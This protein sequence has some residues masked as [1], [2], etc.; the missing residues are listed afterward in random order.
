MSRVPSAPIALVTVAA[1]ALLF[2]GSC[3]GRGKYLEALL[4]QEA[5]RS[6]AAAAET[7]LADAARRYAQLQSELAGLRASYA[8]ERNEAYEQQSGGMEE[9]QRLLRERTLQGLVIDSLRREREALASQRANA[10]AIIARA[11]EQLDV[12]RQRIA[13]RTGSFLPGQFRLTTEGEALVLTIDEAAIFDDKRKERISDFGDASLANLA[14]AL[15]GRP[16]IR[17]DVVCGPREGDGSAKDLEGAAVRA[18]MVANNLVIGH[19]LLPGVVRAVG[20]AELGGEGVLPAVEYGTGEGRRV[21]RVVVRV[22]GEGLGGVGR[23]LR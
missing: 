1:S 23:V 3:V 6:E 11:E 12:L 21:M 13:S 19:G 16:D 22:P 10:L 4:V 7:D 8:R 2:L 20:V 17:V 15:G 14:G 9:R 5:A 18:A